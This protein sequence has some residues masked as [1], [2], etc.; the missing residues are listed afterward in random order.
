M[1][2]LRFLG[3]VWGWLLIALITSSCT[4]VMLV[5]RE[6]ERTDFNLRVWDGVKT[7][8]TNPP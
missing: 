5:S 2:I 7:D 1:T 4:L 6:N 3:T 8:P